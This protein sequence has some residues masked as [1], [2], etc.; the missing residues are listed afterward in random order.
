MVSIKFG[1]LRKER[2]SQTSNILLGKNFK[3]PILGVGA[4]SFF[5]PLKNFLKILVI[6]PNFLFTYLGRIY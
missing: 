4:Y 3:T 2:S 6:L 5:S 1:T